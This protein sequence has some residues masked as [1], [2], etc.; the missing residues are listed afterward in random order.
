[1]TVLNKKQLLSVL[2]PMSALSVGVASADTENYDQE[3]VGHLDVHV[4]HSHLDD[5]IRNATAKG[6]TITREDTK[7]LTG[8]AEETRKNIAEAKEYYLSKQ[9]EII[10]AMDQYEKDLES[11]NKNG[12]SSQSDVT[13]ANAVMTAYNNNLST[14]GATT[15]SETKIFDKS[16]FEADKTKLDSAVKTAKTYSETKSGI[17]DFDR[18]QNSYVMFQTQASQGTIKLEKETVKVSSIEDINKYK[19]QIK[20]SYDA[21]QKHVE[22]VKAGTVTDTPTF[23]LYTLSV[24]SKLVEEAVKPVKVY[25]YEASQNKVVE[26]PTVSYHLYDIRSMP[27]STS[28]VNNADDEIIEIQANGT[29]KTVQAMKNQI[30]KLNIDNEKLPEGRFDKIHNI[31]STITLPE[32]VEF[33][34]EQVQSTDYWN[35][36]YNE[37]TRKLTY[38]ATPRYL[39]EVNK[40][41]NVNNGY[42]SGSMKDEFKYEIPSIKFKLTEDNKEVQVGFDTIIND[43]YLVENKSITI[44]TTAPEPEKHNKDN[45]GVVIDGKTLLPGTVNNFEL[46]WDFDQYNGVN[47]DKEMQA[48][49]LHA[50][51]L[52]PF[53]AVD[54]KGPVTLKDG[55]KVIATG[56]ADGTFKG[57]DNKV[58][59]GL[60]WSLIDKVEGIEREGKAVRVSIQGYDHPY[61]KEY[62]EK[63]KNLKINIPMT[64]KKVVNPN[65]GYNG[66]TYSNVFYQDDFGNIY[67]S[68]E[69][70]NDVPK[71]DPRKDAVISRSN[72]ASLDLKANEKSSIEEGT[73][74]QYRAKGTTLPKNVRLE[75][76]EITDEF[77]EAD[78]YDGKYFV[79]SGKEIKFKKGTALYERYKRTN[80]VM[81]VNTDIT[82]YTTQVIERNVSKDVNTETG[83]TEGHDSKITRVKLQFDQDFMDSIDFE[84]TEFQVDTFFQAKR[85]TQTQGVTN[86][87]KEIINGV[88]F[89]S[90][91]VTTNTSENAKV[92]LEKRLNELVEKY[93]KNTEKQAQKDAEQDKAIETNAKNISQNTLS[94]RKIVVEANKAFSN[95]T[96]DINK[97]KS[98]QE[99]HSKAI[100]SLIEK[101]DKEVENKLD[102][103]KFSTLKIYKSTITTEAEAIEYTVNRGIAP[104]SIV[105]VSLDSDNHFIV[106]YNNTKGQATQT[107]VNTD[108]VKEVKVKYNFYTLNSEAEVKA[109]L[110]D[111]GFENNP[112]EIIKND[113]YYT[114]IVYKLTDKKV[115]TKTEIKSEEKPK[116]KQDEKIDTKTTELKKNKSYNFITEL[117]N[118]IK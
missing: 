41:Q 49:G 105:N 37:K 14:Y 56:Q 55:D 89:D 53:E 102:D 33:N 66:N 64:T 32:G 69:V 97:L 78:E 63:G 110:K 28:K 71:I 45:K 94:I 42:I 72:L 34:K 54:F 35:V 52:A 48:K 3:S 77:H 10:K 104:T 38:S 19:E 88:D 79:E 99:T 9:K 87:F 21:L 7:I 20:K 91:T 96:N 100:V 25:T 24:D 85:L 2:A 76:Y 23:K 113:T 44:K 50:Y 58:I 29:Y 26:K 16:E 5:T 40:K 112:V 43:E 62:V 30:I 118:A 84:N 108:K 116:I 65:G 18:L 22:A 81:P 109:K 46:T 98:V 39:V 67:K 60:T 13:S 107:A 12:S 95:V 59:E 6:I 73:Y 115:E 86:V 114:A 68:N 27:S 106:K 101:S 93:N 8:N 15:I 70:T 11:A 92:L 51:D 17:A 103:S 111:L 57:T 83:I 80:G 82:K 47:I 74:F 75:T 90:T 61:Y 31:I 4:D 36:D 117:L 1:M